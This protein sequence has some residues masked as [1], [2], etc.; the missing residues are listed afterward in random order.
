LSVVTSDNPKNQN[1]Q[2]IIQEIVNGIRQAGGEYRS[3]VDR[4][5][6]ILF[7][8]RECRKGDVVLIA[9]KGHET[10]QILGSTELPF[11]EREIVSQFMAAKREA[12]MAGTSNEIFG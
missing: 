8:L 9:G 3:F 11:N 4:K 7:A 1:R 2:R 12:R 6:A 10:T 5:E